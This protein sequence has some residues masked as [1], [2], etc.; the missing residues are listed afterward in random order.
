LSF[1]GGGGGVGLGGGGDGTTRGGFL[2]L[3]LSGDGVG[4][5]AGFGVV[6]AAEGGGDGDGEPKKA[7]IW[8]C[9][10]MSGERPLLRRRD[11]IGERPGKEW[12]FSFTQGFRALVGDWWR[13]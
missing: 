1:C 6:A 8:L 13:W 4:S 7:V 12:M 3:G 10:R 5:A 11:A 9:F 2:A